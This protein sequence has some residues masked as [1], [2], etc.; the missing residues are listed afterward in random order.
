M[1]ELSIITAAR[2][3]IYDRRCSSGH[4]TTTS[5][6][7]HLLEQLDVVH[8]PNAP[9]LMRREDVQPITP[10]GDAVDGHHVPSAEL[11]DHGAVKCRQP[12]DV[13]QGELGQGRSG[14]NTGTRDSRRR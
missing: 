13:Q 7:H 4:G 3:L 9:A 11:P 10:G 5:G 12:P 6:S 1:Q 8:Q 2:V 14:G